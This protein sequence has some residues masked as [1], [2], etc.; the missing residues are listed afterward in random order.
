M[1]ARKGEERIGRRRKLSFFFREKSA[2][3][4]NKTKRSLKRAPIRHWHLLKRRR[5]VSRC[6]I[7]SVFLL[8]FLREAAHSRQC[9]NGLMPD[10]RDPRRCDRTKRRA[11]RPRNAGGTLWRILSCCHFAPDNRAIA[12]SLSRVIYPWIRSDLRGASNV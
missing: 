9:L 7:L 3:Q 5:S 4:R 2:D 10:K 1:A 11:S 8:I 12:A 6:L